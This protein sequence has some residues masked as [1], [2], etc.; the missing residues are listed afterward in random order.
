MALL[1][2]LVHVMIRRANAGLPIPRIRKIAG[3]EAIDEAIGRATEMGR[4]MHFTPGMSGF[5]PESYELLVGAP[6]KG[7]SGMVAE[8]L[9]HMMIVA[10]L[11]LGNIGFAGID[12]GGGGSCTLVRR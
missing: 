12:G 8:S 1:F 9:G 5:S 11:I 10:F 2:V 6:G 4:P 3:L 7:S